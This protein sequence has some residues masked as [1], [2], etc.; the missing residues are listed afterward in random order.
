MSSARY[1]PVFELM[2]GFF[3]DVLY[4]QLYSKAREQSSVSGQSITDVYMGFIKTYRVGV[5]KRELYKRVVDQ[6]WGYHNRWMRSVDTFVQFENAVVRAFIPREFFDDLS[7]TQKDATL[8]EIVRELIYGLSDKILR[9]IRMAI[10]DRNQATIHLL[11]DHA[12]DSCETIMANYLAKFTSQANRDKYP[13]GDHVIVDKLKSELA[14]AVKE[15]LAYEAGAKRLAELLKR[16]KGE[17]DVKDAQIRAL[18]LDLET[19]NKRAAVLEAE[20]RRASN[21]AA[22]VA[23]SLKPAAVSLPPTYQP[24]RQYKTKYAAEEPPNTDPEETEGPSDDAS[25]P[26]GGTESDKVTAESTGAWAD[27][28]L[29]D[30]M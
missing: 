11:Q 13:T 26:D 28:M 21:N 12:R 8:G 7:N 5:Q 15:K 14:A 1:N 6:L 22:M 27:D 4:N 9:N 20:L 16:M 30:E 19:A 3:V 24:K 18:K 17:V 2:G 10:D 23:E 25:G 29:D